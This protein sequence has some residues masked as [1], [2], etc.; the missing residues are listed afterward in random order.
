MN[1]FKKKKRFHTRIK[2]IITF[3]PHI[4]INIFYF[5]F[6]LYQFIYIL[7][8][9]SFS[10]FLSTLSLVNANIWMD[11]LDLDTLNMNSGNGGGNYPGGGS[12]GGPDPHSSGGPGSHYPGGGPNTGESI[13][14]VVADNSNYGE[15]NI[16]SSG[17]N[18]GDDYIKN[19]EGSN[20]TLKDSWGNLPPSNNDDLYKLIQQR[21]ERLLNRPNSTPQTTVSV[22]FPRSDCAVDVIAKE[23]LLSYILDHKEQLPVA[24]KQIKTANNI[25][26]WRVNISRSSPIMKSLEET[27]NKKSYRFC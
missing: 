19:S 21:L 14:P 4:I 5:L 10:D 16:G 20:L 17:Q 18:L 24:Y 1:I 22:L 3:K 12:F 9:S 2:Y 25:P 7:Y 13:Y 26:W 6:F 11:D 27:L 15:S 23:R 8:L